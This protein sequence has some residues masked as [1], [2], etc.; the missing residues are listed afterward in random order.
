MQQP[1]PDDWDR[2]IAEKYY[3]TLTLANNVTGTIES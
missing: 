2:R 1:F 3:E